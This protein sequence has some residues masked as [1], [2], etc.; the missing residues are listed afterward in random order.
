MKKGR[1]M[2]IHVKK[3]VYRFSKFSE[4]LVYAKEHC[5]GSYE[6][7]VI[8]DTEKDIVVEEWSY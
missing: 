2:L 1:Y 7:Y 3:N 6:F 8:V 5:R 4:A